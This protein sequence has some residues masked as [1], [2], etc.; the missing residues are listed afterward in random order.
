MKKII[1]TITLAG[2]S[3]LMFLSCHKDK[4]DSDYL[5]QVAFT[6]EDLKI[7][8]YN[9]TETL[10]FTDSLGNTMSFIG[11]GRFSRLFDNKHFQ[12]Y[13]PGYDPDFCVGDYFD[14]ETNYTRLSGDIIKDFYIRINLSMNSGHP[15]HQN[16]EKIIVF[17]VA[18][19][20]E[21]K[22]Y[23][24]STSFYFNVPILTNPLFDNESSII[25]K[26]SLMLDKKYYSSVYVLEQLQDPYGLKNLKYL[27]YT[28]KEGIVGFKTKEGHL[29]YLKN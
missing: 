26:D 8:P 23:F 4:C 6:E 14:T 21:S 16:I 20:Y 25:Y 29:W 1:L 13:D 18:Y 3:I 11:Q 10:V 28:I 15:F 7:V 17:T 22:K 27:Y 2:L 19:L 5:G 24:F 12:Y 9:G